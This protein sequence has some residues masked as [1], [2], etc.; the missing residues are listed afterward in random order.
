M[1]LNFVTYSLR[2]T[3]VRWEQQIKMQLLGAWPKGG[4]FIPDTAHFAEF[5][6]EGLLR[7][8]ASD[9][10]AF[11]WQMFQMGA[12]SPNEIRAIE[13]RNA[14]EDGDVYFRPANLESLDQEPAPPAETQAPELPP[15]QLMTSAM[16]SAKASDPSVTERFRPLV[17]RLTAQ[18]VEFEHEQVM[19][20]ARRRFAEA[21]A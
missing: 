16:R 18:M 4:E 2:P 7:G 13:N 10:A 12:I 15:L 3:L 8:K 11:L 1:G 6:V 17:E 9:R 14:T 5:N 19:A 21:A 20:E